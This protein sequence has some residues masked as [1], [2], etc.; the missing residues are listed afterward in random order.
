MKKKII[1]LALCVLMIS[2][3]EIIIQKLSN[4]DED[5]VTM[6]DDQMISV[7]DLY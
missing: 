3:C 4:G 6:K 7:D 1:V 2:G 5:I